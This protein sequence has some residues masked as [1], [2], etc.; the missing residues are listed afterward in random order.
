VPACLLVVACKELAVQPHA[1][2]ASPARG[3]P[4]RLGKKNVSFLHITG[5]PS[6]GMISYRFYYGRSDTFVFFRELAQCPRVAAED[7]VC[8]MLCVDFNFIFIFCSSC[9]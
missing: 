3:S 4:G 6:P 8:M 2:L 9:I 5:E 1:Q 7:V